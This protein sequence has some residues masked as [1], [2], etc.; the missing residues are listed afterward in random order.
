MAVDLNGKKNGIFARTIRKVKSLTVIV[1]LII[2]VFA[3]GFGMGYFAR[4]SNLF[5]NVE[6]ITTQKD[7]INGENYTLTISTVE[8]II[9]SA[10][11][12]VISKFHYKDADTYENYKNLFGKKIPFTTD[13][14]VFTYEGTVAV[15]VDLTD[16]KYDINNAN[17]QITIILP[18]IKVTSNE[19]DNSSFKFPFK[20]D[21]VFNDSDMENYSKMLADL[22]LKKEEEVL[23]DKEFMNTARQNSEK[24]L[25][26]FLTSS[27]ATKDYTVLFK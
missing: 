21:S 6:L 26:E 7:G 3:I 2:S 20:S 1:L 15:G 11:D 17:K 19:I 8:K 12:L 22:K 16:V 13:M 14:F 24:I 9:E 10:S 5:K 23:K 25:K 4:V 27:D 18:Q